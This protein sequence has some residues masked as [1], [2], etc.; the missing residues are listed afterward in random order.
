[1][2]MQSLETIVLME[3]ILGEACR[4]GSAARLACLC[5]LGQTWPQSQVLPIHVHT[6]LAALA[7]IARHC[8]LA[9][10][11]SDRASGLR[12]CRYMFIQS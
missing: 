7:P 11:R 12:C 1:M 2:K 9:C 10:V 5:V 6:E 8:K 3:V 4:P